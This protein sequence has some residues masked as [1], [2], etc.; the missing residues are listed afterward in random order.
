MSAPERWKPG[1]DVAQLVL[2]ELISAES[3]LNMEPYPVDQEVIDQLEKDGEIKYL[4]RVDRWAAHAMEH[5][6]AASDAIISGQHSKGNFIAW[7]ACSFCK[8]RRG[9]TA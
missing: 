2:L 8:L 7:C 9:E 4:S 5:M 3:S 1:C 6:Q